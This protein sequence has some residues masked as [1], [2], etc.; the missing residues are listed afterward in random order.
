MTESYYDRPSY[1]TKKAQ[2][3]VIKQLLDE[4]PPE[5]NIPDLTTEEVLARVGKSFPYDLR[6]AITREHND[7]VMFKIGAKRV[8]R[9]RLGVRSPSYTHEELDAACIKTIELLTATINYENKNESESRN[10]NVLESQFNELATA[11]KGE[12]AEAS[13]F[14]DF[15]A[16]D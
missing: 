1:L 6:F 14:S 2:E 7:N 11:Q 9:E 8:E 3:L 15:A 5:Q 10:F 16:A 13:N 12:L 4:T